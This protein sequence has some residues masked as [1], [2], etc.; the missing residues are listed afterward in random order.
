MA[1]PAAHGDAVAGGRD[2]AVPVLDDE[3]QL[4]LVLQTGAEIGLLFLQG[5]VLGKL[6]GL[7]GQEGGLPV[8]HLHVGD[9]GGGVL[10]PGG[11]DGEGLAFA[12]EGLLIGLHRTHSLEKIFLSIAHRGRNGK[13]AISP[14]EKGGRLW[15]N[16]RSIRKWGFRPQ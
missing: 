2:G 13:R 5:D 16:S 3:E 10:H 6:P 7:P 1:L 14:V 8:Y 12:L 15:Y 11:A 9:K 4:A